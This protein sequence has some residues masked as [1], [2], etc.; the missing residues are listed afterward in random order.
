[1]VSGR[2]NKIDCRTP[3]KNQKN[4]CYVKLGGVSV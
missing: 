4:T 1:M 3:R 2:N